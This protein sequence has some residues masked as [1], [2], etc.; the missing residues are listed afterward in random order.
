MELKP[1]PFCG[2]PAYLRLSSPPEDRDTPAWYAGCDACGIT[3]GHFRIQRWEQGKGYFLVPDA[4]AD[5][6]A[7]WNMRAK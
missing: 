5:A 7:A 2:G 6:I 3:R 4:K 1:C